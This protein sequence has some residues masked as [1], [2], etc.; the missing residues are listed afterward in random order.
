MAFVRLDEPDSKVN[1]LS[2]RM[3]ADIR[4]AMERVE[5]DSNV[6]AAVLVSAKPDCFIAG[7]DI[8]MLSACRTADELT[9]LSRYAA[10]STCCSGRLFCCQQLL[11]TRFF[12]V[13]FFLFF[14]L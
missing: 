1:T 6:R 14:L 4:A 9:K 5:S 7:A 11:L 3:S 13:L 10:D 2:A 12:F 8:N